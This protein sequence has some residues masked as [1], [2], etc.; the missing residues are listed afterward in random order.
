LLKRACKRSPRIWSA[1]RHPIYDDLQAHQ[2]LGS[3]AHGSIA[4]KRRQQG[5]GMRLHPFDRPVRLGKRIGPLVLL[6]ALGLAAPIIPYALA[7]S[8][9]AQGAGPQPAGP[10]SAIS[11]FLSA[12]PADTFRTSQLIG[13]TVL[14][15]TGELVGVVD[16]LL[17]D[18]KGQAQTA[19]IGLAGFLELGEKDV[20][21]PFRNLSVVGSLP[22]GQP[23]SE[24]FRDGKYGGSSPQR[25]MIAATVQDLAAAPPYK[26]GGGQSA[27][28]APSTGSGVPE[29]VTKEPKSS[30]QSGGPG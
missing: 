27:V 24:P 15:S 25:V 5:F 9:P 1:Y 10:A 20:A 22:A 8:P 14:G 23:M 4:G 6:T 21:V 13:A 28:G 2:D 29:G 11:R 7:Q 16:D 17:F 18:G 26:A 3:R 19:V 30:T 12:E